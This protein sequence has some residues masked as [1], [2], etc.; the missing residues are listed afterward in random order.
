[1][2]VL[3][4]LRK[5]IETKKCISF[6]Y[7]CE[8]RAEGIRYGNPHAVFIAT[9]KNI[10]VHIWKTGGVCTSNSKKIPDWREYRISFIQ[11]VIVLED[12]ECFELA[13]GYKPYSPRYSRII[14]R[15]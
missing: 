5:A 10:N 15:A 4:Y 7:V 3:D 6:E 13:Q 12:E 8:N 9:S 1:M 14:C 11:N 2:E